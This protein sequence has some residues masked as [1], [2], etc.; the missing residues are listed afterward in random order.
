MS[1]ANN[2][3]IGMIEMQLHGRVQTY[4]SMTVNK[5]NKLVYE[6]HES[7][8]AIYIVDFWETRRDPKL[9]SASH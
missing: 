2:P 3:E 9:L 8:G 5:R 1:I 4:R 6:V 7:E